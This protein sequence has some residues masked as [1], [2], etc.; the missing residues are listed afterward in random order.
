MV[1]VVKVE[2]LDPKIPNRDMVVCGQKRLSHT[3]DNFSLKKQEEK[4]GG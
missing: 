2:G 3:E 4:N 1:E